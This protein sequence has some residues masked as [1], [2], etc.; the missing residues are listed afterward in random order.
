MIR[1]QGDFLIVQMFVT[2]TY[3]FTFCSML[4]RYMK[5]R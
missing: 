4:L 3:M 5:G 1:I 2:S